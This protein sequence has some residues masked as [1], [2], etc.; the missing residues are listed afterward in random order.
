MKN[1]KKLKNIFVQAV[2]IGGGLW[3]RMSLQDRHKL[4]Y[5][6]GLCKKYACILGVNRVL[7]HCRFSIDE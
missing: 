5:E 1:F 4:F 2:A 3:R 7:C 6:M